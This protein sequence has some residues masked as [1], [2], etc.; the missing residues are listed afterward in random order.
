MN[1]N[2]FDAL[3]PGDRVRNAA[4]HEADVV[5]RTPST[6]NISWKAPGSG[7]SGVTFALNRMGNNW[8]GLDV[9]DPLPRCEHGAALRDGAGEGLEPP[10]GCRAAS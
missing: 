2:E 5:S 9:V 3:R 1:I 10:C 8:W 6:V 7:A 4:G